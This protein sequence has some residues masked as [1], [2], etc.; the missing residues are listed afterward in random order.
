LLKGHF[1][2]VG[3]HAGFVEILN[4]SILKLRN[5]RIA[6]ADTLQVQQSMKLQNE[7]N[8]DL[9]ITDLFLGRVK[10]QNNGELVWKLQTS[11]IL[12]NNRKKKEKILGKKKQH[13]QK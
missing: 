8:T 12:V 10:H 4:A 11:K 9:Y 13:R 1:T 2:G 3:C 5:Y 7:T 6:P